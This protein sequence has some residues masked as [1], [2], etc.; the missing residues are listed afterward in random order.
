MSQAAI[1]SD[2]DAALASFGSSATLDLLK[3]R[4]ANQALCPFGVS[5]AALRSGFAAAGT[6][7]YGFR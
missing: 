1:N 2:S 6:A 4:N 5:G 7:F 3:L